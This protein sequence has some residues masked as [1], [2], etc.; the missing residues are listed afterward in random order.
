MKSMFL[1]LL[2]FRTLRRERFEIRGRPFKR[3][4]P[5]IFVIFCS[6]A[7]FVQVSAES[8]VSELVV[9]G[10][11]FYCRKKIGERMNNKQRKALTA[12]V[13]GATGA[14]GSDLVKQL[15]ED[16]VFENIE[17]FSRRNIV[18]D[19]PKFHVHVIDFDHPETWKNKVKGDV[20]FSCLGTTINQAGSEE[21]Q[22]KVDHDYQLEFAKAAHEN[23][24]G[25]YVLISSVGADSSSR[26]FYLRMKGT[27][28]DNVK[29]LGIP[30]VTILQPPGLIRK[31]SDR[32]GERF[33]VRILK[34]VNSIGLFRDQ[35][36]MKT[37]SVAAAMVSIAKS[38]FEGQ[39]TISAQHIL[40][41]AQ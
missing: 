25:K 35:R 16:D 7:G 9:D 2:M 41:Y 17:I 22:W 24:V 5:M 11:V 37:E 38:D 26:L 34:I 13:I 27:L 20:L 23:G 18:F 14:V 39:K 15:R 12:I 31:N 33:L 19:H 28:E 3:L 10:S 4:F 29:K 40:D 32:F 6:N 1:K 8:G 36:P 30:S 21:I